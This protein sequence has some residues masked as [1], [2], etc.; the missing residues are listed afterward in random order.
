[1]TETTRP[2]PSGTLWTLANSGVGVALCVLLAGSLLANRYASWQAD[3]AR[4]DARFAEAVEALGMLARRGSEANSR[5]IMVLHLLTCMEY[6]RTNDGD[7]P[8][9]YSPGW[10]GGQAGRTICGDEKTL[11]A[12]IKAF[13]SAPSA[14]SVHVAAATKLIAVTGSEALH[15]AYTDWSSELDRPDNQHFDRARFRT[16]ST[17]VE[18]KWATLM[19]LA[20]HTV[21]AMDHDRV[22]RGGF[23]F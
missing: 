13:G 1:M 6:L 16:W 14:S 17:A 19:D 15:T 4:D 10:S 22:A 23:L 11:D 8:A 20:H 7:A 18:E 21:S 9:E 2:G 5:G 12:Q 3:V